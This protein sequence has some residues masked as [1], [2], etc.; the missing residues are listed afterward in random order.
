MIR[1]QRPLKTTSLSSSSS[2]CCCI[3]THLSFNHPP[4][5]EQHPN[6]QNIYHHLKAYVA[7]RAIGIEIF[8][9]A[10]GEERDKYVGKGLGTTVRQRWSPHSQAWSILARAGRIYSSLLPPRI[11]P[12]ARSQGRG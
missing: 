10:S 1:A 5:Q 6:N 2:C 4:P 3:T 9:G 8:K 7:A 12:V 11:S